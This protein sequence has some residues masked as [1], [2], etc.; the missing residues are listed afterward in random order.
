MYTKAPPPAHAKRTGDVSGRVLILI[1]TIL[2]CVLFFP[3]AP[4]RAA[5]P[6]TV[7]TVVSRSGAHWNAPPSAQPYFP[8]YSPPAHPSRTKS[9]T[10]PERDAAISML[11][12]TAPGSVIGKDGRTRVTN[13]RDLPYRAIVFLSIDFG[14][15]TLECTGILIGPHTVATA[16]HCV[17][18]PGLG[19]AV[20]AHAYPALDG[21]NTPFPAAIGT[22][23]FTVTGWI[24][25]AEPEF[26]YGAIQ[27][28]TDIGNE[29]GWLGMSVLDNAMLSKLPV[30]VTGY[31]ADKPHKTMWTM[32]GPIQRVS[33]LRLFYEIDTYAGQSGSPVY[34]AYS[35]RSCMYCVVGIHGYGTNADPREKFNSGVRITSAVL[36]NYSYWRKLP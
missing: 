11:A 6:I 21:K 28:D 32:A 18:D 33:P 29:T 36:N 13:T 16:G 8:T 1:A 9:N 2:G 26:D 14:I 25:S 4:A 3:A 30:R 23:F 20:N 34:N 10:G 12:P 17:H 22:E 35:S 5:D 15:A 31:P 7:N 19:W 27:L 24:E